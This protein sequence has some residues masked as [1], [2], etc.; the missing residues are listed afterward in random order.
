[1]LHSDVAAF[2]PARCLLCFEN[3]FATWDSSIWLEMQVQCARYK[4]LPMNARTTSHHL[5]YY[6]MVFFFPLFLFLKD[7]KIHTTTDHALYWMSCNLWTLST[8]RQTTRALSKA[9]NLFKPS[10]DARQ[11][12]H[13]ANP[14][15]VLPWHL[16]LRE[17]PSWCFRC[18][19]RSIGN[20]IFQL[21][22]FSM[23]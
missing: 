2:P 14:D 23:D 8:V 4:G 18:W 11:L 15:A 12:L 16:L 19:N 5:T 22:T 9:I 1:M 20:R 6:L 7:H 3:C 13:K 21:K 17:I 10:T